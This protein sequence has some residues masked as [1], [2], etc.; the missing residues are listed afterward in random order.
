ML[1]QLKIRHQY[2]IQ[3]PN[4]ISHHS[5]RWHHNYTIS[6]SAFGQGCFKIPSQVSHIMQQTGTTQKPTPMIRLPRSQKRL[7]SRVDRVL[8]VLSEPPST[9]PFDFDNLLATTKKHAQV[10]A[11]SNG[12]F[13]AIMDAHPYS[14]ISPRTEFRPVQQLQSIFG[15]HPWR[16]RLQAIVTS[17]QRCDSCVRQP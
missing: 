9:A 13:Q 15:P 2:S 11:T 6:S 5:R 10:L 17:R 3:P 1:H 7:C 12:N 8:N 16:P 4:G 14:L